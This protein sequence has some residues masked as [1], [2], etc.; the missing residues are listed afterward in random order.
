MAETKFRFPAGVTDATGHESPNNV[1]LRD[2]IQGGDRRLMFFEV[3]GSTRKPFIIDHQAGSHHTPGETIVFLP[4][5]DGQEDKE[6]AR[7]NA[8]NSATGWFEFVLF[9]HTAQAVRSENS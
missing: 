3:E 2:G 4:G 8:Y 5:E 1:I 6:V 7:V 9:D